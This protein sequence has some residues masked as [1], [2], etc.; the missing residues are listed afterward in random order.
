MPDASASPADIA[1]SKPIVSSDAPS[2]DPAPA[3]RASQ[4]IPP[5]VVRRTLAA[6][7]KDGV[8][9]SVMSGLAGGYIGP[10]VILGGSGLIELAALSALPGVAAAIVQ[11]FAAE[12][13]D[14]VGRRRAIV[15]LSAVGQALAMLPV[16]VAIFFRFE[17]C[18]WIMLAGY[19]L[20]VGLPNFG[21]P[22]WQS[23]MGDLV[24]ADRRGGYF[25]LRNALCGGVYTATFLIAGWWLVLC[26]KE[27]GFALLGLSGRNFGFLVLFGLAGVARCVSAWY[28]SRMH[29]VPYTPHPRDRF[30]LLDFVRRAPR[31]HFGR[32]VLYLTLVHVGYGFM[33]PFYGWYLLD[34]CQFT[35]GVYANVLVVGMAIGVFTHALWGRLADRVGNKRVITICGIGAIFFPVLLLFC[36]TPWHFAAV[37]FY[38]GVM[39]A[40]YAIATGN[41]IFDVVSPPKRARCVAY[42]TL[43]ITV[44]ITLGA[45]PG[46]LV[47]KYVPM[48]LA[49]GPL[50]ITHAFQLLLVGSVI[51]RLLANVLLLGSFQEFR[52]SRPVFVAEGAQAS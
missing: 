29:D 23:L 14:S 7:I 39:T 1:A 9:A 22:A 24:P 15:V 17:I 33:G 3:A 12:V 49:L 2:A 6:S 46:A 25:G 8:A 43:F 30:T 13:T 16:C 5:E 45:F 40:G 37:Q 38:D 19:V 11:C 20:Y 35:T 18:Y 50:S 10:F 34:Q 48:P 41:Y 51:L 21:I 47:A 42:Y 31:A 27:E 26:G 44:G 36:R 32:F 28:L 4:A 52:L